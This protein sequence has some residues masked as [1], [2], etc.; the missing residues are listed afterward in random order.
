MTFVS[1]T[2]LRIR[3]IRFLPVFVVYT[4]R[5]RGQARRSAGFLV[6]ALLLDRS[7]T[8]WTMTAW[9][10]EASMRAYRNTDAHKAAMPRLLDWCDEA[11]IAHWF[12]PDTTLPSWLEA[13]KKMREIGR[14]SKVRHPSPHHEDLSYRTPR[15]EGSATIKPV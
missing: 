6:G 14:T 1:L 15:T 11:S 7:W 10:D 4:L 2:R 12:Q 8:F 3:S 9:A 5:A 13:D